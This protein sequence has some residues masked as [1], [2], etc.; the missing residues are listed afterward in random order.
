M[1]LNAFDMIVP[2]HQSPGLWRHPEA[3]SAEFDTLEYWTSLAA[4]LD[5]AGFSTLFLADVLG[6]YDVFNNS[7]EVAH[8]TGLQYPVLDPFAAVSAMAQSSRQLGF[9]LTASVTYEHP[10]LLARRLASLDH[11]TGGRVGWNIVTSYQDSAARNMGL[12]QQIPH[13]QRYDR[14][15]EFMEVVYKLWEGS[16]EPGAVVKDPI[17]GVFVDPEKVHPIEHHGKYF[18]VP[19]DALAD[20]GPQRTP[21]LFQAGV[22]PRGVEFALDHAEAIFV[23]GATSQLVRQWTDQIRQKLVERGRE[24]DA[25]KIFAMVTVVTGADD[26]EAK[27]RLRSYADYVDVESALALFSGWTG[28]DFGA[29]RPTDPIEYVTTDANR[30]ALAS[31]TTLAEAAGQKVFTVADVAQKV[32][33]GG[34]GPVLCGGPESVAQQLEEWKTAAGVDGFNISGAVRSVDLERFVEFVVPELHRRGSVAAAGAPG[35]TLRERVTGAGPWLPEDHQG[36]SFRA[37]HTPTLV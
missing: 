23:I 4:T 36:S 30:S 11:F 10:Y 26:A 16:I 12:A 37:A 6:T 9:G 31:V 24:P 7:A 13:D 32:A 33:L 25:I 2:N 14:A 27:A 5:R 22:S 34:R 19:G 1:L 15:D 28:I 3:N 8:R 29:M 18:D 35:L 20:P 21:F 17:S